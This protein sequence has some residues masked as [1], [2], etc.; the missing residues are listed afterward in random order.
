VRIVAAGTGRRRRGAS[1]PRAAVPHR[2]AR[3]RGCRL[4]HGAPS[5]RL[6]THHL[7][8]PPPLSL[9]SWL[10]DALY[11]I[12]ST[13]IQL[14]QSKTASEGERRAHLAQALVNLQAAAEVLALLMRHVAGAAGNPEFVAGL[15]AELR[16]GALT[17]TYGPGVHT[18]A[19]AGGEADSAAAVGVSS[20]AGA[21]A[22]AGSSSSAPLAEPEI[23]VFS[24]LYVKFGKALPQPDGAAGSNP[25]A[26]ADAAKEHAAAVAVETE[27]AAAAV[28][29]A[30]AAGADAGSSSSSSAAASS[31]SAAAASSEAAGVVG[32]DVTVTD[33]P[34]LCEIADSILQKVRQVDGD[35]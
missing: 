31:S 2:V 33:L 28:A 12:G 7:Q 1:L 11:S 30:A 24:S 8:H 4:L 10:S 35:R 25:A 26:D 17:R 20:G 14:A 22:G 32:S 19:V 13:H 3:P 15:D 23:R 5:A 21:G 9:R 18:T 6:H 34:E 29:D 27:A 16:A